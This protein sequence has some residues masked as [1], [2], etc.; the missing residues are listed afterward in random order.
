M[1]CPDTLQFG[2]LNGADIPCSEVLTTNTAFCA[3]WTLIY[4][5]RSANEMALKRAD[6]LL[7]VS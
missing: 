7:M 5:S 6:A 1:I 3:V 4:D 2:C